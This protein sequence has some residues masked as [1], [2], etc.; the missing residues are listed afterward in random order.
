MS[1]I[2]Q[3]K[4]INHV[5]NLSYFPQTI[6]FVRKEIFKGSNK[7][8]VQLLESMTNIFNKL[9]LDGVELYQFKVQ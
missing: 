6:D 9:G 1:F 8:K 7:F 2:T 4:T 5:I 3:W